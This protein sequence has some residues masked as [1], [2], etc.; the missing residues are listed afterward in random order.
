MAVSEFSEHY[1]KFAERNKQYVTDQNSVQKAIEK[2]ELEADFQSSAKV[3]GKEI[4]RTVGVI[5]KRQKL[6]ENKW[7]RKVS[8]F[9]IKFYPVARFSLRLTSAA[10]EVF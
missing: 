4:S 3:F 2:A 8:S 6:S 1:G 7:R 9:L 10:S 5:D